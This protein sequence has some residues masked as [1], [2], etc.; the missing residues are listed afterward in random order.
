LPKG[1]IRLP[2][3]CGVFACRALQGQCRARFCALRRKVSDVIQNE[4]HSV[5]KKH[6]KG[7]IDSSVINH[8][9]CEYRWIFCFY[10]LMKKGKILCYAN[11]NLTKRGKFYEKNNDFNFGVD[12]RFGLFVIM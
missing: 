12:V 9:M 6:K 2:F 4:V 3:R 10:R 1:R 5:D 8:R 7:Y 11:E